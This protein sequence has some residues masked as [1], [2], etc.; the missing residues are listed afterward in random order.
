MPFDRRIHEVVERY[1]PDRLRR[2]GTP[3]VLVFEGIEY[4]VTFIPN[5]PATSRWL[6]RRVEVMA[7]PPLTVIDH[8]KGDYRD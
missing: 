2:L 6:I 4:L 3:F 7:Y 1:T 5:R 8:E